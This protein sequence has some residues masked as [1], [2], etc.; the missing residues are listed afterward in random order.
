MVTVDE[1]HGY[2]IEAD[3]KDKNVWQKAVRRKHEINI[4]LWNLSASSGNAFAL[5]TREVGQ[6]SIF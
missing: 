5:D 4:I 1:S 3:V 6:G 2:R